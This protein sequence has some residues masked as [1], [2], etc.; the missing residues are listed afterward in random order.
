M[1]QVVAIELCPVPASIAS[2][3]RLTARPYGK[4]SLNSRGTRGARCAIPIPYRLP[5]IAT[6]TEDTNLVRAAINQ[7]DVI[8]VA[9]IVLS[10]VPHSQ[11]TGGQSDGL[12]ARLPIAIKY[13]AAT[14]DDLGSKSLLA[15]AVKVRP[16]LYAAPL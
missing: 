10:L 14:A 5:V 15:I 7:D 11:L 8:G 1:E 9:V 16:L 3:E 12:R 6:P 2:T 4:G 13:I